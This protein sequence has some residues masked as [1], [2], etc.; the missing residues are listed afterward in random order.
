MI[1]PKKLLVKNIIMLILF[2]VFAICCVVMGKTSSTYLGFVVGGIAVIGVSLIRIVKMM[3]NEQYKKQVEID[4]NDERTKMINMHTN[5]I[6]AFV[7]IMFCTIG[8]L[9][10]MLLDK[11]DYLYIF[12]GIVLLWAIVYLFVLFILNK[13]Y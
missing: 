13:K 8:A 3:H 1:N 9:V 10:S 11:L 7:I 4:A 12:G 2:V 6:A 5:E